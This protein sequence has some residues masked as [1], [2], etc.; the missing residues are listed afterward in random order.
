MHTNPR[1]VRCPNNIVD[2]GSVD[3]KTGGR[4]VTGFANNG[5]TNGRLGP[6]FKQ[7]LR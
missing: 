3:S 1:H 4:D 5:G 2:L 6:H 7:F